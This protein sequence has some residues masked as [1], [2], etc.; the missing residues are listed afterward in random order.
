MV[1][2]AISGLWHGANWNYVAWGLIHGFYQVAGNLTKEFRVKIYQMTH[3][4]MESFSFRFGQALVTFVM[5]DFAWIFF[6]ARGIKEAFFYILRMITVWN[7]WK[8]FDG[9]LYKLGLEMNEIHI[10]I[11][12]LVVLFLTDLIRYYKKKNLAQ[13]LETQCIWFRW[14]VVFALLFAI[15]IYGIYGVDFDSTQ[16]VY[17]QF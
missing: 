15:L 7:P 2:F 17:F 8:L 11:V 5:V 3:T 10:L 9:S 14:S 1:T 12:S 4:K 6:R 13:F 16:F